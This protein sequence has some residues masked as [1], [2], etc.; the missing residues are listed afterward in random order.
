MG[1]NSNWPK[2]ILDFVMTVI[3]DIE[4]INER[5]HH[6]PQGEGFADLEFAMACSHY[7]AVNKHTI[8]ISF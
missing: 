1:I 5:H 6:A 7:G 4:Y 2:S 3:I 8:I